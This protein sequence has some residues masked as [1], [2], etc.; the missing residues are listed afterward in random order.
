MKHAGERPVDHAQRARFAAELDRNFSVIAPAGVGKT[1]AIVDR[2]VAIATGDPERARVWL[3]KLAVVTYTNK[4]ADEMHQ[5]ARNAIIAARAGLPALTAFNRAFFGTIHRFCV[6]LIRTHG[7]L[8]GLPTQFEAIEQEDELWTSFVRQLDRLAPRLPPDTVAAVTRLL[9]VNALLSLARKVTPLPNAETSIPPPP[10]VQLQGV[11]D[12]TPKLARSAGTYRRSQQAARDWEQAWAAAAPFAPLPECAPSTADFVAA[13][14]RAF[15]PLREWL[16]TAALAVARE[17][18]AAYREYRRARGALTFD[19]QIELAR[20]LIRHPAAGPELR[21]AGYR[22]ILD[23]AQDTDPLQFEILLELARPPDATGVWIDGEGAP[24]EPGRFCMVGDPQ[25]SIYGARA[26]LGCYQRVRERL[27]AAPESEELVFSVTFR[28]DRA[29][30]DTVNALVGPAFNREQGQVDYTPL[31]P[32]PGAG[33]GQ[34]LCW[35]PARIDTA[36]DKVEP[37]TVEFGRQLAAWLRG[38][39]LAKLGASRWAD[40]AILC[41]RNRW[42]SSLAIGLREHGLGPQ[43]HSQR[44][45]RAESPVYTWFT[46][47]MTVLAEPDNAFEIV[48]VL[49]EIYGLSDES[50]ARWIAGRS[51]WS[52]RPDADTQPRVQ[53]PP[54]PTAERRLG[55]G[56]GEGLL[57]PPSRSSPPDEDD[58]PGRVLRALSALA[59][60]VAGLPLRDA[61]ARA[62]EATALA[63][64]VRAVARASAVGAEDAVGEE[65]SALYAMAAQAESEGL[66]L[67][68]FAERLRDGLEEELPARPVDPNAAQLMTIYKAKGLQWPVVVLPLLY[69]SIGE[70]KN[71]PDVIGGRDPRIVFTARDL[72]PMRE[73]VEAHKRREYQR[74]LY[75]GLTRAQRTLILTDDDALFPR[76]KAT[77]CFAHLLGLMDAGGSRIYSEAYDGLPSELGGVKMEISADEVAPDEP[78]PV[79]DERAIEDAVLRLMEAPR[80]V[81]PYQLG[82]AE[83]RAERMLDSVEMERSA[84]AEAAR[85]YGIWW[86]ETVERMPWGGAE[87]EHWSRALSVCPM[88]ERGAREARLLLES[89]TAARLRAPHLK[90]KSEVPILWRR[91][92]REA[93]E[94][95][96][97]LAVWDPQAKRWWILDWKTNVVSPDEAEAH[98]KSIYAPQLRAYADA[99]RAV[100]GVA[101]ECGVYS[102]ATGVWVEI[103]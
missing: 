47:L 41:P 54:L 89:P 100:S 88:P 81:L 82:E 40:V 34:V 6:R 30:V 43:L 49:R 74:L 13:W 31:R 56:R 98:L 101:V 25:Q 7:H 8:C 36:G 52:L 42:L 46:A 51:G 92:A 95:V 2:V 75:V 50:L 39:G 28:C 61:A 66:S 38:Q 55:E 18:A 17:I 35:Q 86:H 9:P 11:Y 80:R 19:D 33:P 79:P 96:I 5:R 16:G 84:S 1:K 90:I 53:P 68:E 78:E 23:E 32:R 91:D 44:A 27:A 71:Y 10:A 103:G 73:P 99:L 29:I 58:A 20:E 97:D 85:A 12:Q 62:I 4:A 48:G 57:S 3:P 77:L 60:E 15:L 76:K 64:R 70:S 26:D 83:A 65:V 22:V 94:G 21:R 69:R 67:G 93:V 59:Q 87:A 24:P 72:D 45:I 63:D 37:V 14:E 102:T